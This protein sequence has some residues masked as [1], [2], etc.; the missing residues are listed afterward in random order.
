MNYITS[1]HHKFLLTGHSYNACDRDFP[2]IEKK[3]KMKDVLIPDQI[4][5]IIKDASMKT[6]VQLG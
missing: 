3:K 5:N 1:F 4:K 6:L 2:L